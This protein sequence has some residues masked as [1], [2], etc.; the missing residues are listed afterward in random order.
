MLIQVASDF[1][2]T[3]RN[4]KGF[5]VNPRADVLVLAGDFL[6]VAN[7][8]KKTLN[9]LFDSI[10]EQTEVPILCV[11]GNH[12]YYRRTVQSAPKTYRTRLERRENVFLLDREYKILDG[13][14]FI[15]CTL[16]SNLSKPLD[17]YYA[18]QYLN[19][20]NYIRREFTG[21]Q[22]LPLYPVDY[23]ELHTQDLEWLK[24]T[25]SEP[26]EGSVVVVTHHG[27]TIQG[28]SAKWQGDPANPC[29]V[30]NLEYLMEGYAPK[31]WIYGHTHDFHDFMYDKTRM[32][33]NPVGYRGEW[34]GYREQFVV[35][36]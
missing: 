15:G 25:L 1:H 36:V 22:T 14:K 2:L 11:M 16:W 35:E 6:T 20:F 18:T 24:S 9:G 3:N 8:S 13:V 26:S 17:A 5:Q 31:L 12:D 10:Q 34:T 23:T 28:I 30:T 4:F 7:K 32:V 29:Y 33:C 19:D 21:D 27:P